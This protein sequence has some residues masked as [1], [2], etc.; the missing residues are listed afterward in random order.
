MKSAMHFPHSVNLNTGRARSYDIIGWIIFLCHVYASIHA[1]YPDA[2][3]MHTVHTHH[4]VHAQM[5]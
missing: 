1:L 2:R 3:P 5:I 4:N